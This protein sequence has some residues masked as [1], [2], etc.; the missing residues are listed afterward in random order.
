[1]ETKPTATLAEIA[2]EAG[3]AV[4]TVSKVLNGRPGVGEEKRDAILALLDARGYQRRGGQPRKP[5]RMIDFV[6]RGIDT[7]WATAML[8]GAEDEAAR[9]GV[10]LVVSSTNGRL[11]GNRPWLE[12]IADR[13]S[14]GIVVIASRIHDGIDAELERLRIPCV[15]VD[16]VGMPSKNVAVIGATNFAGGRDAT[17]HLIELGHERIATI[18]GPQDLT[19]S[20]ERVDGYRAALGRAGITPPPEYVQLGDF[21]IEGGYHAAMALFDLPEPPTAIC[22]GSDLQAYGVYQAAQER[23]IGIPGQLSVVGFDDVPISQWMTPRLTTIRQPL[24]EMARQAMRTVLAMAYD[25]TYPVSPK[26][27]LS[28][29]LVVRESTAPPT[30][31]A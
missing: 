24:E 25:A 31:Q 1:M 6:M 14:D 18:T 27:E 26:L 28:T 30:A 23:G 11:V 7:P 2:A 21:E 4:A 10:G 9:A 19:C 16:M 12:R 3:V 22:A 29:T 13:H 8:V 17:D 15:M 5:A 20:Q